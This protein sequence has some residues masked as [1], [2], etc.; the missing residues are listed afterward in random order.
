[1]KGLVFE[2]SAAGDTSWLS[3]AFFERFRP[4]IAVWESIQGICWD[5][6]RPARNEREARNFEGSPRSFT[7]SR[8]TS[9]PGERSS[10]AQRSFGS[11][12]IPMVLLSRFALI[13]GGAPAVPA[14]RL[15]VCQAIL[16]STVDT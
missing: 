16:W 6:G 10:V 4:V 2:A 11:D 12:A 15:T 7:R 8:S 13:A 9:S 14:N 1:L 3:T 5:R